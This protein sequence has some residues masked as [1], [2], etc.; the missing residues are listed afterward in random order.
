MTIFSFSSIVNC[1]W[2]H[3]S[4]IDK[5]FISAITVKDS[6]IFLGGSNLSDSAVSYFYSKD[7]GKSWK[8]CFNSRASQPYAI[9][10]TDKYIFTGEG[11]EGGYIFRTCDWGLN[12]ENCFPE[13][14]GITS[15]VY[16]ENN[17]Y[18]GTT[19]VFGFPNYKGVWK[20]SVDSNTWTQIWQA[21]NKA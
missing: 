12:W 14:I 6:V 5:G 2:I 16:C 8:E 15:M 7:F 13:I 4:T 10:I 1:Q 19:T 9:I 21:V 11:F 3:S 17:L 20:S 18:A